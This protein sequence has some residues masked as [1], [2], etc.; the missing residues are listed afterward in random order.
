MD[1][2]SGR[3]E[4]WEKRGALLL[5]LVGRMQ[6]IGEKQQRGG[7]MGAL[8]RGHG[9]L[10]AAVGVAAGEDAAGSERSNGLHGARNAFA[11]ARGG[12][13]E[14]RAFGALLAERKIVAQHEVSGI[15]Q[16]AGEA[17]QQRRIAIG[18]GAVG[19]NEGVAVGQRG[20][21]Q[22]AADAIAMERFFHEAALVCVPISDPRSGY[23]FFLSCRSLSWIN[24]RIWSAIPSSFSH[25]SRYRVTGKRPNPYTESAPFS[26]TLRNMWPRAAGFFKASFSARSFAISACIS[27]SEGM[28]FS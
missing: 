21:M 14:G 4:L 6:R 13:R 25:C 8:R 28:V 9:G 2:E 10:P 11:V 26:L 3:F 1:E 15:R 24:W 20:T 27:S 19:Q 23:S 22:S 5:G 12:R 17:H 18:A 16:C 7:E